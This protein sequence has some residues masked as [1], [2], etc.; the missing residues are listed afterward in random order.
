MAIFVGEKT[1]EYQHLDKV[2][3]NICGY[4]RGDGGH[5]IQDG[6]TVRRD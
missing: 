2:H 4:A 1:A 3:P 6:V 5:G